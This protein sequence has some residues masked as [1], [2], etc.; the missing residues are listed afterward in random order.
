MKCA[1]T[2]LRCCL[3]MHTCKVCMQLKSTALKSS[4]RSRLRAGHAQKLGKVRIQNASW[5]QG[6]QAH[7][8]ALCSMMPACLCQQLVK[9]GCRLRQDTTTAILLSASSQGWPS[10]RAREHR[11]LLCLHQPWHPVVPFD[12]RHASRTCACKLTARHCQTSCA[13]QLTVQCVS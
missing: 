9:G 13:A 10:S 5:T 2:L 12:H 1:L 7:D 6:L 11:G 8:E 3:Q 4:A